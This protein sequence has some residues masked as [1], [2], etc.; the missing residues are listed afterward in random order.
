MLQ[1]THLA[2]LLDGGCGGD[3]P[4]QRV[5]PHVDRL[6]PVP[7]PRVPLD[8]LQVL[9]RLDHV[10]VDRVDGHQLAPGSHH[11]EDLSVTL[12]QIVQ[13][14]RERGGGTTFPAAGQSVTVGVCQVSPTYI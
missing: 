11:E 12:S 14:P 10:P 6:H 3:V 8:R 1:H 7:L 13:F 9:L 2:H 5:E 4:L